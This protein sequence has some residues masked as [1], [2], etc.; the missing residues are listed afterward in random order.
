MHLAEI[1]FILSYESKVYFWLGGCTCQWYH[2][3]VD[4]EDTVKHTS[5]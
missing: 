1:C 2:R 4:F 3:V 5:N